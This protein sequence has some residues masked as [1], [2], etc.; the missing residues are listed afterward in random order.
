MVGNSAKEEWDL[1]GLG[2]GEW[3][4]CTYTLGIS[5]HK[6]SPNQKKC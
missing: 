4:G 5:I 6:K 3:G 1:V 2:E